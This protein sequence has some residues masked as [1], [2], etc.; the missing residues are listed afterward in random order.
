MILLAGGRGYTRRE[1]LRRL[2]ERLANTPGVSNVRYEPS[3]LRPRTVIGEVDIEVFLG[4]EF[5]RQ[6]ATLE[7]TWRP[8]DDTDVQRIHWSDEVVS[9][10][11]HKDD[12]H[13]DLGTTHFQ[14]ERECE[15]IHEPGKIE[16]EAPVSFLEIC[17]TRLPDRLT[18]TAKR[19]FENSS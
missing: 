14:Y 13:P 7:V 12:D 8:R 17:L 18:E 10:G 4:A 3:R 16:V 11:W 5:P 2:K 6:D 19:E 15:Q 1:G 9:L